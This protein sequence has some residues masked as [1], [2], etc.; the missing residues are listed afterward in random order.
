MDVQPFKLELD[1]VD[2]ASLLTEEDFRKVAKRLLQAALIQLGRDWSN[3]V[4]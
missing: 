3:S 1:D 2:L 4:V